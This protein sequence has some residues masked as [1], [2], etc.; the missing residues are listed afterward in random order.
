MVYHRIIKIQ[1]LQQCILSLI[2]TPSPQFALE[3][4]LAS[5]LFCPQGF[6]IL[7]E[8]KVLLRLVSNVHK[9][10]NLNRNFIFLL[11]FHKIIAI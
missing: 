6:E 9:S 11:D 4:Q 10:L 2:V 7:L 3:I 8:E 1:V 5:S